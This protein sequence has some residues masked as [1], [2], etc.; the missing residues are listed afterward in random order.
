MTFPQDAWLRFYVGEAPAD[1][2]DARL[3]AALITE[4]TDAILVAARQRL[5]S[6]QRRSGPRNA[7]ERNL[8]AIR[9]VSVTPG[10]I[11]VRFAEP[12]AVDDLQGPLPSLTTAPTPDTIASDVIGEIRRVQ[13]RDVSAGRSDALRSSVDRLLTAASRIGDYAEVSHRPSHGEP[14]TVSLRLREDRPVST[15]DESTRQVTLYG[16][17]YMI[18]VEVG[19]QRL[20]IKLPDERDLTMDLDPELRADALRAMDQPVEV[21]VIETRQADRVTRR[22]IESIRMLDLGERGPERPPKSVRELAAE[23]GLLFRPVPDYAG[24]A[25]EVWPTTQDIDETIAALR[26]AP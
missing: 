5:G 18:D 25:S 8:A 3:V 9:L 6:H 7:L 15:A 13:E 26:T 10:S 12:P 19:R 16:H 20:R 22:A 11:D 17:S 4:I 21:V 1:G 23:Q 2:V 14:E 24:L